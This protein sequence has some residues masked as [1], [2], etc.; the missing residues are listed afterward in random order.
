MADEIENETDIHKRMEAMIEDQK[1]SQQ[2]QYYPLPAAT[3][4][5]PA[6]EEKP[7]KPA[8]KAAAKK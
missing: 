5:E 6:K 1:R 4:D 3:E 7:A 8:K 2:E